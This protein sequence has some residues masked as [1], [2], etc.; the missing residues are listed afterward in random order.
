MQRWIR[1]AMLVLGLW[2][3]ASQAQAGEVE[4]MAGFD[5]DGD[6]RITLDEVMSHIRPAVK[7]GFDALDRNGDGVLSKEDFSDVEEG[8]QRFQQWLDDLLRP[9]RESTDREGRTQEF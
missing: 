8:L 7:Q 4:R 3:G 5:A 1:M 9:F 2:A 6:G